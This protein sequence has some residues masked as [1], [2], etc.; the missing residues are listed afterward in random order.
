V[1][2]HRAGLWPAAYGIAIILD[3]CHMRG[4]A[5]FDG[6]L[7]RGGFSRLNGLLLL[8][9]SRSPANNDKQVERVA[10]ALKFTFFPIRFMYVH[11]H[12]Q[13]PTVAI[14]YSFSCA[15]CRTPN[16]VPLRRRQ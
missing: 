7:S 5:L 1:S 11:D 6:S 15:C 10:P 13:S 2:P 4:S 16:N 12:R 8:Y 3:K 14:F 9:R